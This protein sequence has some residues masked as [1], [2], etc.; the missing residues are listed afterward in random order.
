MF[1]E[2]KTRNLKDGFILYNSNIIIKTMQLHI[3]DVDL[4]GPDHDIV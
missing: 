4:V 1:R 3:A 2:C